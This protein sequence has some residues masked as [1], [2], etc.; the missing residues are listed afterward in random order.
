MSKTLRAERDNLERTVADRTVALST[1]NEGLTTA[2]A[3]IKTLSGL[4]PICA[5]CKKI[6]D[7]QGYWQQVESYISAR[8]DA[9]FSHGLC[10]ECLPK[11][12]SEPDRQLAAGTDDKPLP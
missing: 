6:R 8:S 1:A 11:Y 7:D 3:D 5:A 12:F 2:L 9:S 4:I 10:P